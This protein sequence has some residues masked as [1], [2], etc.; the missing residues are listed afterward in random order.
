MNFPAI[1]E[2]GDP[3]EYS[4]KAILDPEQELR[5]IDDRHVAVVFKAEET[6]VFMIIAEEARDADGTAVPTSLALSGGDL[7][8]LTVHHRVG[9]PV[10]GGAPFDYPISPGPPFEVGYSTVIVTGPLQTQSREAREQAAEVASRACVVP[11]L[12]G[13]SLRAAKRQLWNA[14]C[15]I[16]K[17]AKRA[18]AT[19]R[20]GKVVAQGQRAGSVRPLGTE[21]SVTL[22]RAPR[23]PA[24]A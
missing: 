5:Q 22:G 8:T 11:A 23:T 12:R 24:G 16:G 10:A 19:T 4:W 13:G 2:A 17:V 9:N 14:N 6:M 15:S 3:E 7:L 18:G 1:R 20:G 21:V